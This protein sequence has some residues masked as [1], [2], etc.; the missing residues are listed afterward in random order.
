MKI[1]EIKVIFLFSTR[2]SSSISERFYDATMCKVTDAQLIRLTR[3]VGST[4]TRTLQILDG[5]QI[6]VTLF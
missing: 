2:C 1:E 3:V 6:F 5:V 4:D